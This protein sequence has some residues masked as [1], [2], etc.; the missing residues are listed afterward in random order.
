MNAKFPDSAKLIRPATLGLFLFLLLAGSFGLTS[1]TA[2]ADPWITDMQQ[3]VIQVDL[4]SHPKF[5]QYTHIDSSI[6][7]YG[8]NA[9]GLV[10]AAAAVGGDEW[11]EVVD[12]IASAAGSDY[13]KDTGIQPSY[14][15]AALQD[16]FGIANVTELDNTTLDTLYAELEQGNIVIVDFKVNETRQIPSAK[17]PSYAHFARVLGMDQVRKEIY[18]ENTLR[19]GTYWTVSYDEFLAAWDRPETTSS[20]IPDPRNAEDVTYWAVVLDSNLLNEDFLNDL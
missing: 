9:C 4:A 8:K 13:H 14:Y 6:T 12:L 5:S 2:H 17:T 1:G 18:I 10:A 16:V 20:L 15:V 11:V 19:G 7:G 3:R